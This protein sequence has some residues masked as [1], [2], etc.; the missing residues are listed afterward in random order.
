M[1]VG[2]KAFIFDIH[3]SIF[4]TLEEDTAS[5]PPKMSVQFCPN[6]MLKSIYNKVQVLQKN[7]KIS[8]TTASQLLAPPPPPPPPPKLTG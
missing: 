1:A 6:A 4:S 2:N 7:Y 3:N 8:I 5:H